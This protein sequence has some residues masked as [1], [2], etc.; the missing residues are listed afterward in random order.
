MNIIILG[1]LGDDVL[2]LTS[3]LNN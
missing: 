2:I 3:A 1:I